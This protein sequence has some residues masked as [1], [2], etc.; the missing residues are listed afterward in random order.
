MPLAEYW[1]P[2]LA[3]TMGFWLAGSTLTNPFRCWTQTGLTSWARAKGP[4]IAN[5]TP[6]SAVFLM[7]W[8]AWFLVGF[9]LGIRRWRNL[10]GKGNF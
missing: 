9:D 5:R 4:E 10:L 6:A 8:N 7:D 3:L 2:G 1:A